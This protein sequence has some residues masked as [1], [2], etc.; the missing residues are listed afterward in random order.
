M[1]SRLNI[2]SFDVLVLRFAVETVTSNENACKNCTG[3]A[4]SNDNIGTDVQTRF[5]DQRR[6]NSFHRVLFSGNESDRRILEQTFEMNVEVRHGSIT[7]RTVHL[8]QNVS[9]IDR[10]QISSHTRSEYVHHRHNV[11]IAPK[12]GCFDTTDDLTIERAGKNSLLVVKLIVVDIFLHVGY[13]FDTSAEP[14]VEV[15]LGTWTAFST[16]DS[17]GARNEW[18]ATTVGSI[19]FINVGTVCRTLTLI[20]AWAGSAVVSSWTSRYTLGQLITT[21]VVGVAV[22]DLLAGGISS[23]GVSERTR[24]EADEPGRFS[25][26]VKGSQPPFPV[27]HSLTSMHRP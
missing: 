9:G 20:A 17:V 22:I 4:Q 27:A 24:T 2:A 7:T 19:T 25:Q 14:I 1:A 5:N 13:S 18:V 12:R 10:A 3:Q 23:T 15:K 6:R 16:C 21:A 8:W 26:R 11:I